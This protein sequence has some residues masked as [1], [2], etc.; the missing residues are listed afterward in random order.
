M[1]IKKNTKWLFHNYLITGSFILFIIFETTGT[2]LYTDVESDKTMIILQWLRD[3][4]LA[5]GLASLIIFGIRDLRIYGKT[6]KR[7]INPFISIITMIL[8]FYFIYMLETHIR[9]FDNLE[10]NTKKHLEHI[11][12]TM[13]KENIS[14]SEKEEWSNTYAGMYYMVFGKSIRYLKEGKYVL[15]QPS[16]I[17]LKAKKNKIKNKKSLLYLSRAKYLWLILLV[18][19]LLVGLLT[20]IKK[21]LSTQ[22][23]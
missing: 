4:F 21:Q 16:E 12:Q 23:E 8:L 15:Y 17:Q 20:P 5:I 6:L 9:S 18:F 14:L 3:I 7:F 2:Y 11:K 1:I 13:E 10:I 19:S 22:K